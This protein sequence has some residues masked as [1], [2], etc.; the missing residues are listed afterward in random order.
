MKPLMLFCVCTYFATTA[1]CSPADSSNFYFQLALQHKQEGKLKEAGITFLKSIAFN[2]AEKKVIEAYGSFLFESRKFLLAGEQFKK[3]LAI[4]PL[5]SYALVKMVEV[6]SALNRFR[7]VMMYGAKIPEHVKTPSLQFMLGKAY[8]YEDE[9]DLSQQALNYVINQNPVHREALVLLGKVYVD[10]GHYKKAIEI[11]TNALMLDPYNANMLYEYGLLF[12]TINQPKETVK[13]LELAAEKGYKVN[14]DFTEN[15][16]L[17][18]LS[19]DIEKGIAVLATVLQKKPNNVEIELQIA[20]AY[21]R[22]KNYAGAADRYYKMYL[23][24]PNNSRALY[25]MGMAYQRGG[26]KAKGIDICEQA[27]RMN[28]DLAEH[29]ILGYSR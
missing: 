9:Y 25:M 3:V 14:L 19:F 11:Y 4:D 6:S 15:L 28:S 22:S 24:D 21:Y 12:F 13:Y 27:I 2:P 17:A 5:N 8:Y 23:H 29:K 10:L 26:E 20:N 18:Y 1:Y 16:G 7:E